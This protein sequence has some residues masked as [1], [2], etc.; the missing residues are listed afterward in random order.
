MDR[1]VVLG[2]VAGRPRAEGDTDAASNCHFAC[3]SVRLR[4]C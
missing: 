3:R 1:W 4:G 2:A